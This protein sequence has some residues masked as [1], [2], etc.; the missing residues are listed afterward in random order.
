MASG[1]NVTEIAVDRVDAGTS[2]RREKFRRD[3]S[4]A[5]SGRKAGNSGR[6]R[7]VSPVAFPSF[8]GGGM[9]PDT[10]STIHEAAGNDSD[11]DTGSD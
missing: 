3:G 8:Q 5:S 9:F 7:E 10:P 4:R 1:Q 6:G 11:I 2:E